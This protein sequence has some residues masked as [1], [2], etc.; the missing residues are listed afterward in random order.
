M[1]YHYSAIPPFHELLTAP[2][3][4]QIVTFLKGDKGICKI[5]YEA[6]ERS[7]IPEQ[8]INLFAGTA[9]VNVNLP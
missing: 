7:T 6:E 8:N 1:S 2:H 5:L 4:S 3:M 9:L